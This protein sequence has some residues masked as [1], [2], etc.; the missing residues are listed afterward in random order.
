MNAAILAEC[1]IKYYPSEP[2]KTNLLFYLLNSLSQRQSQSCDQISSRLE[3]SRE[4]LDEL[5]SAIPAVEMNE[6]GH[7]IAVAGLSLLKTSYPIDCNK[8]R[9]YAQSGL[10]A[11]IVPT[12]LLTK[13]SVEHKCLDNHHPV[14]LRFGF[15]QAF[16]PLPDQAVIT[17]PSRKSLFENLKG[18]HSEF[19]L[20][21]N[22]DSAR[23]WLWQHQDGVIL[24]VKNVFVA[25][26]KL[27][28][29]LMHSGASMLSSLN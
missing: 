17:I 9:L 5:L 6:A 11:V 8:G 1:L 3:Y 20:F 23:R 19:K 25:A 14:F 4:K 2:L 24:S 12:L 7:I 26:V 28:Q 15:E 29:S 22:P 10:D 21:P 16:L 13:M 18:D 27:R